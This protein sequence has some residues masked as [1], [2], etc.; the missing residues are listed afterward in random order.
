[1]D[2]ALEEM[3]WTASDA[4]HNQNLCRERMTI[5]P[6]QLDAEIGRLVDQME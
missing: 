5:P 6:D 3:E 2:D 1:M 4:R